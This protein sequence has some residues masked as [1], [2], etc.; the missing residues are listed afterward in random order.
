MGS[1]PRDSR[2]VSATRARAELGA[3]LDREYEWRQAAWVWQTPLAGERVMEART[4]EALRRALVAAGVPEAGA[5]LAL[6]G[7]EAGVL[8]DDELGEAA[9][10]NLQDDLGAIE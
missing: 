4:P 7:V 8:G 10:G 6:E 9:R 5:P 2:R 1:A 3:P